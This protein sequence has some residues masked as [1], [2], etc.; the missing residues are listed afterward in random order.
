MRDLGHVGPQDQQVAP[1]EGAQHRVDARPLV[2]GMPRL[3]VGPGQRAADGTAIVSHDRQLPQYVPRDRF[4]VRGQPVV[5]GL[6]ADFDRPRDPARG[7][8]AAGGQPPVVASGPGGHHG[9]GELREHP[10]SA[11]AARGLDVGHDDVD[12]SA[13]HVQ[14][15]RRGRFRDRAAQVLG[16][17]RAD[18]ELAVLHGA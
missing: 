14:P 3:Q 15:A 17:H 16:R 4:L 7:V 9:L 18:H 1:G 13:L 2:L 8:V 10:A 12:E 5:D 11:R 6:G